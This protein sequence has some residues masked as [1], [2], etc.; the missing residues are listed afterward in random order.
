M[1]KFDCKAKIIEIAN[2]GDYTVLQ[3][4][5]KIETIEEG[6]ILELNMNSKMAS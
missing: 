2:E 3:T 5:A 1:N 6:Q 4:I